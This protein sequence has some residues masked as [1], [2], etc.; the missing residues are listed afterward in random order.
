MIRRLLQRSIDSG[1]SD[2]KIEVIQK[3]L[4]TYYKETK[5]VLTQFEKITKVYHI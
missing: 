1:R 4:K 2:D 3:R 5:E